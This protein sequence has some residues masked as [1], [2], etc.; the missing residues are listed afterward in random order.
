MS[1]ARSEIP[2]ILIRPSSRWAALNLR[3][4]WQFRELV[5]FMTW[6]DIMVRY[7]Q[8][9][10]GAG[11]AILRPFLTMVVF[12]IFFG[13]LAKVP[14]DNLPYPI[15]AFSALLPWELFLHAV[16]IGSHSLV[17]NRQMITKVYFPRMILPLASVLAG[18]VDFLIASVVLIGP[19]PFSCCL[20]WSPGSESACGCHR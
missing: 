4:L 11:W 14:S 19:Y 15:F 6:R 16:N 18:V 9:L 5:F 8:T 1:T 17:N 12:S 2:V 3:E 10:L 20:P 13:S 7:K